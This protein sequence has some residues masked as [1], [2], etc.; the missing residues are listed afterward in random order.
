MDSDEVLG[1]QDAVL[2]L[3]IVSNWPNAINWRHVMVAVYDA[4]AHLEALSKL[5]LTWPAVSI[6]SVANSWPLCLITLLKVFS[7]VG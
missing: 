1:V 3:F 7:M 4:G 6:I 5:E 2:I